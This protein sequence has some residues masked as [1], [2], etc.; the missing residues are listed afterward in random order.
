M[1]FYMNDLNLLHTN[2]RNDIN[3]IISENTTIDIIYGS[4]FNTIKNLFCSAIYNVEW[5]GVLFYKILNNTKNNITL[6]L[7]DIQLMNVGTSSYTEYNMDERVSELSMKYLFNDN[8]IQIGNIH[9]HH[10]M[11]TF[12]SGTDMDELID[13]SYNHLL[14]LSVIVNNKGNII[15]KAVEKQQINIQYKALDVKQF[16]GIKSNFNE[17]DIKYNLH[18]YDTKI[19]FNLDTCS[20]NLLSIDKYIND[21]IIEKR[22]EKEKKQ[23]NIIFNFQE[24]LPI[25]K[26]QNI[27]TRKTAKTYNITKKNSLFNDL[28]VATN[29]T[30]N[31]TGDILN[32]IIDAINNNHTDESIAETIA[33]NLI[34]DYA[35]L[36]N[37]EQEIIYEILDETLSVLPSLCELIKQKIK[38]I[39]Q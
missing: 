4:R 11:D 10:N 16:T 2:K 34:S 39:C 22:K 27:N 29:I 31:N 8:T 24:I 6:E 21:I 1:F 35:F 37:K 26:K 7:I 5:S 19:K 32:N 38:F 15:A 14:Y 36:T 20:D 33:D 23:K 9:S 13:N 30:N 25:N 28:L 12:F 17:T 3:K 18:I